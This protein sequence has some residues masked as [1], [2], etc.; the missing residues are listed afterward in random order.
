MERFP[1][2]TIMLITLLA[3]AGCGGKKTDNSAEPSSACAG[4]INKGMDGMT[5][6]LKARGSNAEVPEALLSILGKLRTALTERCTQDKWSAEALDCYKAVT[7][8]PE[9][10]AC[11]AKL[12]EEQ[13]TKL[14]AQLRQVMM[15][16]AQMPQGM[17]HPPM[18]QGS[19]GSPAGS[20][21]A[22]PAPAAP[23]PAAT[24]GAAADPGAPAGSAAAPVR[25]T[26]VEQ[27]FA[28]VGSATGSAASGSAA[29][30]W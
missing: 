14:S 27:D 8:Q 24:P 16:G 15:G 22:A 3:A 2:K 25:R 19:S 18:L 29:S 1:M 13:R 30:G 5:A 26:R 12:T 23:A 20:V 21:P 9:V 28:P 4:S 11:Q 17:N 7:S 10:R 6:S